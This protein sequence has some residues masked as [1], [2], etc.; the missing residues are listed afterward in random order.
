MAHS[1]IVYLYSSH[2]EDNA[3]GFLMYNRTCYTTKDMVNWTDHGIITG[4]REPYKTFKWADGNNAWAPQCVYRNG[5]FYLYCPFIYQGQ[6]VIGVVVA[7][8]P[9]RPFY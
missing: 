6:M 7:D 1:G 3:S 9:F 2:E 5:Q 8:K 4:D